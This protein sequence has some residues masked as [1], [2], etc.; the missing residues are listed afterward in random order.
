[1]EVKKTETFISDDGKEFT[2]KEECIAWEAST[3]VYI[4]MESSYESYNILDV[5]SNKQ[6]AMDNINKLQDD[7]SSYDYSIKI[8]QLKCEDIK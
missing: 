4:V 2:T 6:D 1:M 7:N 3:R 5:F 8:K